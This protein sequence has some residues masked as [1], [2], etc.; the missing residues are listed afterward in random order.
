MLRFVVNTRAKP[1]SPASA[2]IR[3]TTSS[4]T[5]TM[6]SK[7]VSALIGFSFFFLSAVASA[8]T[9]TPAQIEQ[10]KSLSPEQQKALAKQYGISLDAIGGTTA[11]PPPVVDVS[12]VKP[13]GVQSKESV[14]D[15][16]IPTDLETTKATSV[17]E[18]TKPAGPRKL[19]QFGYDLFAGVPSTFAPATNI[20]VPTEYVVGPGDNIIVQLY[21]K[22]SA[23]HELVVSREGLLQ[24]PEIGPL[25]VAGLNF[26][27]LK[28]FLNDT[29]SKKM[30]G[31]NASITMG[32]LRS[33]QVFVLG[34]AYRPGSYTVSS[35]STMTNALFVSGGVTKIGS[36]RKV[37][38]KRKGE[39][40]SEL[41]L[42]D[43]LLKGD[44]KKDARLLP[45]DVIFIPPIGKTVGVAGEVRRP[46]IY[47]LKTESTVDDLI[48]LSGGYLST[49]YPAATRIDRIND[50]GERT[51]VDINLAISNSGSAKVKDGDVIQIVP[52]LDKME[53]IVM[54]SGHVQRP[55]G[56]SWHPGMRVKDAIPSVNYLLPD[57]DLNYALIKRES[58]PNRVLSVIA[59]NLGEAINSP[60][61]QSNVALRP[62]D[63]ILV[64]GMTTKVRTKIIEPLLLTL[65]SQASSADPARIVSISGNVRF[66][67][68]YPL[69]EG[70]S[71]QTLIDAAGGLTEAAYS[72]QAEVTRSSL[73]ENKHQVFTRM[74]LALSQLDSPGAMGIRALLKPRDQLFIKKIPNWN[75]KEFAEIVGEVN[76]PGTYPIFPGDTIKTL[77]DR[78][79]GMN[80]RADPS[81]SIFLRE[82]LKKREAE[83]IDKLKKQLESDLERMKLEAT[84][85]KS[86]D[87]QSV[88]KVGSS[89]LTEISGVAPT[90]RLVVDLPTILRGDSAID[91]PLVKGD[92]LVIPRKSQEV[93]VVGEVQFPT[94]HVFNSTYGVFDYIGVSG[95]LSPK[96]NEDYIYVIAANGAVKPTKKH[97]FR[98][99]DPS[100]NPGDTIV[101]PLDTYAVNPVTSWMNVSQILFN[102]STTA[103]A[104]KSVGAF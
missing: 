31:V 55:G 69:S 102:L 46:A 21:G 80:E 67:G 30:I 6:A 25:S 93:M 38:L 43:L 97:W 81:A 20:P 65:N 51:L 48:N 83:Q 27:E 82:A 41:D 42:Y 10:F 77:I 40:I 92:K 12:T 68:E 45:G 44:T 90:G 39:L 53:G 87:S 94:S 56:L 14:L 86:I 24:F 37:Q 28:N 84:Q 72:I 62:R 50:K 78:A 1:V 98:G 7:I 96:A 100:I 58:E 85:N 11:I 59:V 63:E 104:L 36:L 22:E 47:E 15:E 16:S 88:D 54:V 23:S 60:V 73:D 103:A 89:L 49:A 95:G 29:I 64:F 71:A 19:E 32:A 3:I 99:N 17:K 8:I 57:P 52:V 91:I 13:R 4:K 33:I 79:G 35:L 2:T 34:D 66:P 70:M 26:E 101:V 9:P 76:F 61:S 18:M 75:E 5:K 74:S